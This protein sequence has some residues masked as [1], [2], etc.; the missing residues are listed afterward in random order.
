MTAFRT[1]LPYRNQTVNIQKTSKETY[2]TS[3]HV[4]IGIP[5]HR[6]PHSSL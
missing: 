5:M 6:I 3:V 2:A 4:T 1:F